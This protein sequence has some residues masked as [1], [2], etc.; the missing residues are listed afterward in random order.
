MLTIKSPLVSV[1]IPAFNQPS[2]LKYALESVLLQTY[3]NIEIIIGDD[4]T[5]NRVQ[6]M[7]FSFLNKYSNIKYFKNQKKEQDDIGIDNFNAC[8]NLASGEYIN[9]LNHD[10]LFQKEKIEKMIYYFLTEKDI[11]FVTSH[12]QPIDVMGKPINIEG[13]FR[14]YS[15]K[16]S[17]LDKELGNYCL[18]NC[19]NVIGE[20]TTVLFRK[21]DLTEPFCSYKGK[22]YENIGD[23]A[24][25]L[26][27][28]NKGKSV[29]LGQTLSYF[30]MHTDQKS[31]LQTLQIKGMI[32]WFSL[33]EQSKEDGYLVE[34]EDYRT[35]LLNILLMCKG[36][37]QR[38][39][40]Q[41]T[42][43]IQKILPEIYK[44]LR[45]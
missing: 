42:V 5:D 41:K 43:E 11:S 25:W 7:L 31:N 17:V 38:F 24:S 26:L 39:P 22:R 21:T 32:E 40:P 14:K 8:L 27:L 16:V 10:D 12:R 37:L 13:P 15:E 9:Y 45:S 19:F 36:V 1:L 2:Y 6:E 3:K 34:Q 23:L 35:A 4:S 29:Y 18:K 33:I 44:R 28:Q 20:P 30:R